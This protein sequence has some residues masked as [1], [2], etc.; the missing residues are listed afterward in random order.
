MMSYVHTQVFL[1]E[2]LYKILKKIESQDKLKEI[3]I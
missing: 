2:C 3:G 1:D